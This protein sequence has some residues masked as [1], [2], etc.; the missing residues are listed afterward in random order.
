MC[1]VD[2]NVGTIRGMTHFKAVLSSS[3]SIDEHFIR[4][5][6]Q[7]IEFLYATDLYFAPF[8]D[9]QC[10]LQTSEIKNLRE[11]EGARESHPLFL[12]N[13]KETLSRKAQT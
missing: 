9:M 2:F 3:P 13:D 11:N 8:L 1:L 6:L 7:L 12:A 10:L 4:K 5:T